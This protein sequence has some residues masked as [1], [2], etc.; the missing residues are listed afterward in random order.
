MKFYIGIERLQ[1]DLDFRAGI[2][3]RTRWF[4]FNKAILSD[5]VWNK[6]K[7]M[8]GPYPIWLEYGM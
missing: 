2:K 3:I 4:R 7:D 6:V 5:F 8:P 1:T